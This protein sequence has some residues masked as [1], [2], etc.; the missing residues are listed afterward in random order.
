MTFFFLKYQFIHYHFAAV[1][2]EPKA[3]LLN[4]LLKCDLGVLNSV[5]SPLKNQDTLLLNMQNER[6]EAV[7]DMVFEGI[8]LEPKVTVTNQ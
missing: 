3:I 6:D 1:R 4:F 7:C 8:E 2:I 5:L